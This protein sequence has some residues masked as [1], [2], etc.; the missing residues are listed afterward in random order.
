MTAGTRGVALG[1]AALVRSALNCV[2][3]SEDIVFSCTGVEIETEV[4]NKLD[5]GRGISLC[6]DLATMSRLELA[7]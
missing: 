1:A 4:S 6:S 3:S 2:G 7:R 5:R